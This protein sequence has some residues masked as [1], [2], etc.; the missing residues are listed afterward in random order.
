[1]RS[2]GSY[3]DRVHGYNAG[4]VTTTPTEDPAIAGIYAEMYP[5]TGAIDQYGPKYG[6]PHAVSQSLTYY[7]WGPEYS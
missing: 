5:A 2:P 3:N 4:L 6:L 7:F 1:M